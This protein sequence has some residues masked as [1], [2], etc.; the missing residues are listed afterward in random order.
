MRCR[1]QDI[2]ILL[3]LFILMNANVQAQQPAAKAS[4]DRTTILI[5]EPIK[6]NLEANI[7]AGSSIKW[8]RTDTIAHFEILDPG[9]VDSS[10]AANTKLYR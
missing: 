1:L 8:F 10:D 4:V 3:T 7:P 2:I 6:L 9:K 5:G